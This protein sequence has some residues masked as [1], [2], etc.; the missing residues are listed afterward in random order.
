MKYIPKKPKY[1]TPE[2]AEEYI[3]VDD[4]VL[5][6]PAEY[7]TRVQCLEEGWEKWDDVFYYTNRKKHPLVRTGEGKYW[8]YVLSNTSMPDM[9]KI[10]HTKL[11]PEERARQISSTTG[12][13]T[14]F[15]IEF[16]FKCHE[17]EFLENEIHKSLDMY[18]VSNNR[19]FF[20]LPINE[21]ID[22][23]KQIGQKYI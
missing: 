6:Y 8:I 15:V 21:A 3:N 10:G 14:P 13:P 2:E 4:D 23:V 11:T 20:K 16:A 19:E 5:G 1:I 17:G 7:F 18:R 22:I 12:V 9:V